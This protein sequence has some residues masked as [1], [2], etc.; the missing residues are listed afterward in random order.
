MNRT[1]KALITFLVAGAIVGGALVIL[2]RSSRPP[3]TVTLR[4]KV[5]PGEQVDFVMGRANSAQFKYLVGKQSGVKP[6]LAQKLLLKP[7]PHSSL[8]EARISVLTKD[9]GQRYVGVF[10]ETLQDMCGPAAQ[11]T[12]AEQSIR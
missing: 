7:V 6:V 5:S 1:V 3:V 10:L 2:K 8:L 4:I 12:L 11:L 9:D